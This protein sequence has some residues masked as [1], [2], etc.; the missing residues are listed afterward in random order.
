MEDK[1]QAISDK[2]SILR[3]TRMVTDHG[4]LWAF[5]LSSVVYVTTYRRG[6]VQFIQGDGRVKPVQGTIEGFQRR[7]KKIAP[8]FARTHKSYLVNLHQV[9]AVGKTSKGDYLFQFQG[10][11]DPAPVTRYY[12][13]HVAKKLHVDHLDYLEP[14][15]SRAEK[16]RSFGLK[17]FGLEEIMKGEVKTEGQVKWFMSRHGIH[18]FYEKRLK[19]EFPEKSTGEIDKARVLRNIIWQVWNWLQWGLIPKFSGSIRS[20]WYKYIVFVLKRNPHLKAKN[21][22]QD[23]AAFYDYFN[24]FV[25]LGIFTY[26]DFGFRD[27]FQSSRGVGRHFPQ[28]MVYA[29]KSSLLSLTHALGKKYSISWLM[30]RGQVP[31]ITAE[32]MAKELKK[33][34]G[35]LDSELL[36]FTMT[37]VNP[38]GLSI[39]RNLKKR[40]T[41]HGFSNIRIH[42]VI[43][44]SLFTDE[45]IEAFRAP[46]ISWREKKKGKKIHYTFKT[47][48]DKKLFNRYFEWFFGSKDWKGINDKRLITREPHKRYGDLVTIYGLDVDPIS[49]ELIAERFKNLLLQGLPGAQT[50]RLA[51]FSRKPPEVSNLITQARTILE[52]QTGTDSEKLEALRELISN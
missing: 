9:V 21:Q 23:E 39:A 26:E 14:R 49:H 12:A 46:L 42:P 4:S 3:P 27:P 31:W 30:T 5:D 33:K 22:S 28:A 29:E 16:I 7:F 44:L 20:L 8:Q 10:G 32:Y 47:S 52:E 35:D 37:D 36:F 19:E 18:R 51:V 48:R 43:D 41:F 34:V 11:A 2:L 24:D 45:D 40:F 38:G 17:T 1:L 50:S 6:Y 13:P 15:D 25:E